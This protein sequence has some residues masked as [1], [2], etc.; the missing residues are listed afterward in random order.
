MN[1]EI[2]SGEDP[3]EDS[4]EDSIDSD[5]TFNNNNP[6]KCFICKKRIADPE[7][8]VECSWCTREAHTVCYM[9]Y[10]CEDCA[11]ERAMEESSLF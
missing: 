11:E 6:I 7:D 8:Q 5:I 3:S 1:D 10:K 9:K 2:Y 4:S